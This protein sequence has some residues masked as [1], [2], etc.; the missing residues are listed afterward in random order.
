[1]CFSR[2]GRPSGKRGP[3]IPTGNV[4]LGDG[5]R[6]YVY[7][8]NDR[9]CNGDCSRHNFSSTPPPPTVNWAGRSGFRRYPNN[10]KCNSVIICCLPRPSCRSLQAG[11]MSDLT[12]RNLG[13]A[14]QRTAGAPGS[15]AS[16]PGL[17]TYLATGAIHQSLDC[18]VLRPTSAA[19]SARVPGMATVAPSLTNVVPLPSPTLTPP[20]PNHI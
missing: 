4:D 13:F 8:A 20:S 1:M 9:R 7:S 16:S 14:H 15:T 18:G 11:I 5:I 19:S 12:A 10:P 3:T 17:Q 6:I 2:V